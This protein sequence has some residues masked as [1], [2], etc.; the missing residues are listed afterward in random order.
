MKTELGRKRFYYLAGKEF[1]DL[2]P[3]ARKLQSR[4]LFKR[5]SANYFTTRNY[6]M[7]G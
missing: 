5:F 7:S 6:S 1:N 3:S 4:F 2:L